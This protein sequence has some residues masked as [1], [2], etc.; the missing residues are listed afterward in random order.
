MDGNIAM[1]NAAVKQF[2]KNENN[3]QRQIKAMKKQN[4]FFQASQE[5]QNLQG[6][7]QYQEYQE[8]DL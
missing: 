4:I 7:E 2:Q 1:R 5:E 8:S 6:S 3:I